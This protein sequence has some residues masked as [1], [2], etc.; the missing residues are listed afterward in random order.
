MMF[1]ASFRKR[2]A[3]PNTSWQI[4]LLAVVGGIFSALLVVLFLY[5]IEKLQLLYLSQKDN[6][7]SLDL[8][9]RFEL[10][11]IGALLIL[12]VARLTGYQYLRTGIA[13]VLHQL[14][15]AH[16]RIPLPNTV[17]QF[18]G[19]ALALASG[20]SVGK[21][22]PAVHLGAACS[23]FIGSI[24]K[25][26]NNSIRTLC[27]CGIAAGIAATFNTPIAAVIFVMEVILREYKVHMFIPIMLSAIVGSFITGHVFGTQPEFE[28]LAK[29]A[30]NVQHYPA[31]IIFGLLLGFLAYGFNRYLILIIKHTQKYHVMPRLLTA[32]LITGALSAVVPFAMGTDVSAINFS[33]SHQWQIQLLLGLLLTKI[34]MT[35]FALGL[36]IP[37]GIIGPIL[38]IGAIAGACASVAVMHFVPGAHLTSDFAL[39]G[40]AGFMAATLNA[41]LAALLAVVELSRQI[42]IMLPAMIVITASCIASGQFC[43]NKSIFVMQLNI[44]NLSYRN[45]PIEKSL[46]KIGVLAMMKDIHLVD[47]EN[48]QAFTLTDGK[49]EN[50]STQVVTEA[51]LPGEMI[52]KAANNQYYW[53]DQNTGLDHKLLPLDHQATLAEA[54]EMLHEQRCGGVYIYES[55]YEQIIGMIEFD[56]LK[57]YLTKGVSS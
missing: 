41:P 10:P 18:L 34:L 14:K 1:L 7:I 42:D 16:G 9:S 50:H 2:L 26:P 36:G 3:F 11:I 22:G 29:I 54:Y 27:A 45:A 51:I 57:Q 28:F 33:L 20:F 13:F 25:L 49:D 52:K 32:A 5:T 23:S 17:N 39:M 38:G 15:I 48:A 56:Q 6:Y 40:M 37:G 31:L 4:C 30:L 44:L 55:N 46:Q 8:V 24:L 35:I 43:K 19:S 21:E 47:Y 53:L 12:A